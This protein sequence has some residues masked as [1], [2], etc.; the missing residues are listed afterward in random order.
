VV[1]SEAE[2]TAARALA[3]QTLIAALHLMPAART[4]RPRLLLTS[5]LPVSGKSYLARSLTARV[6]SLAR[7]SSDTI[8][9]HLTRNAPTYSGPESAMVHG[10]IARLAGQLLADGRSVVIDATGVRPRDRRAALEA[11]GGRPTLIAWC[12]VDETTAA[13]RLAARAARADPLDHSEANADVRARMA[14]LT[15]PPRSGEAGLILVVTP[16]NFA[17][18]LNRLAAALA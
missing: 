15:T 12:E 4:A 10:T 11:A 6:P 1:R 17:T 5:G 9:M 7:L 13:A 2:M 8:R 18:A 16:A 14:S 3:D